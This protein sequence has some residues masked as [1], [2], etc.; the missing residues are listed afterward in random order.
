MRARSLYLPFGRPDFS[1][2]E[3]DAVSRVIRSGWVGMGPETI[4]FETE[5]AAAAGAP[6]VVAVNSCTSA[7][8]LALLVQGVGPGDEVVCPSLTWCSSANAALYLGAHAVFCDI[9][10]NTLC[11]TPESVARVVTRRTKAV[12]VV[13]Y[14]GRAVDVAA[15]RAA[16]PQRV[17]IVEDAAHAFGAQYRNGRPVGSAGNPTCFSFYANKN[18]STGEGGAVALADPE[19]ADRIRSLRQHALPIDAWKRF[20]QPKSMLMSNQLSELGYKMNYTDLQASLGRVQLARFPKMQQ[21]R[22][23][24]G[25]IYQREL[26]AAGRDVRWQ[27]GFGS[28]RH[29][30]HLAVVRLGPAVL[31]RGRDNLILA[32]RARNIGATVHYAPL[33]IMPLYL[34][35]GRPR[36][37]PVT[38]AV[39]PSL[40]TLPISASMTAADARYVSRHFL[41]LIAS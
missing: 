17:A 29:A 34:R 5:L 12:V 2:A 38:E 19:W 31:Q 27:A 10:P 32:L 20:S 33:H 25:A 23:Q 4:A 6:H 7:L 18:L 28:V 16:L 37:L 36:S 14:G 24:L 8:F 9:D 41:D 15:I 13:H 11:L 39:A 22:G 3:I 40:L 21:R 1:E 35:G 26:K 30:K